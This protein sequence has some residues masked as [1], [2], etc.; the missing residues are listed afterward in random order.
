MVA[1]AESDQAMAGIGNERRAGV[2][3]QRHSLAAPQR[4]QNDGS[5][6]LGIVVVIGRKRFRNPIPCQQLSGDPSVFAEDAVGAVQHRQ[7]AQADVSQIADRCCDE[8]QAGSQLCL[9]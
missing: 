9:R 6:L 8:V 4:R 3:N 5:H 7:G 2:R 1:E